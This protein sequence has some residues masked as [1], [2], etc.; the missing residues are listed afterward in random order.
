MNLRDLFADRRFQVGLA[1]RGLLVVIATP[2]IQ[3]AWFLPFLSSIPAAG[4][5]P[6]SSYMHGGGDPAAFP[7]GLPYIAAF[8]PGVW[9]GKALAGEYGARLGLG[10]TI[11]FWELVLLL[12]L[13][14]IVGKDHVR[15][16]MILFWLSP[17]SLYVGYWH[18][19]LDFFPVALL[20]GS[21]CATRDQKWV[22]AGLLY[23]L[24]VSAKLSMAL[25]AFFVGLYFL[26]RPRLRR[27]AA[28]PLGGAAVMLSAFTAPFLI[29]EGFRRM[30][31]QTPEA[32]K[33]FSLGLEVSSG[34]SVYILPMAY[35]ALL[36]FAWRIRKLDF[37]MLWTFTGIGFIAFLLLTPAS[38]GWSVWALPFLAVHAA[39]SDVRVHLLYWPFCIGFLGLHMLNSSGASLS[40][41][42]LSTPMGDFL[43]PGVEVKIASVMFTLM[44]ASGLAMAAQ[45]VRT[46]IL[47]SSFRS[48]TR[49]PLAIGVSGDSGAGKDSLVDSIAD[50]F[51]TGNVARLSGDDYHLWDRHKPMWRAVT[52]LNPKA[53]E[54]GAFAAN[55]ASLIEN[56][57]VRARHYDHSIGRMSKPARID[58]AEVIAASGL[59]ALWSPALN[60]LYD[61]KIFLDMDEDLRRF[62]KT[63]RDVRSRG[64]SPRSVARSIERRLPDALRF[65]RP[66][67]N[68]ADIIM[69][70]Q[71]RHPS[72]L[73]D[74]DGT[75]SDARLRMVVIAAPGENFDQLARLLTSLCGMQVIEA[76][77]DDGRTEIVIEGE[78]TAED[79]G[80]AAQRLAGDARELLD[81]E[82]HWRPG[83]R[84]V[85]QIIVLDQIQKATVRRSVT[86]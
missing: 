65:V 16:L 38:P 31:L 10:F 47:N 48:A 22:R 23:G 3:T 74:L 70:L 9:L 37:E 75:I 62:L 15:N 12:S 25:P 30:V 69:R 7:Y 17:I 82:P 20:V 13:R 84:G 27:V 81:L 76:P 80:A 14:T 43:A 4:L 71:P 8:G 35:L 49:R 2:A 42:D 51:G 29:S 73:A 53:N 79:V 1:L 64:H 40:G 66:Q 67:A 36:Y 59:H 26:G 68:E 39:R 54:L 18:G 21:L 85:M 41:L 11:L 60:Q 45:M 55:I 34:M 28:V 33:T 78:P 6:W 77:L 61:V 5:D 44:V 86:A 46:S 19:Q 50:M 57:S 58:P 56:R 52:H 32:E 72:V 83:L 24:A 63:Q